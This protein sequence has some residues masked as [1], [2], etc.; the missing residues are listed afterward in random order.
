MVMLANIRRMHFRDRILVREIS[1]RTGLSRNTVRRWLRRG[2][3]EPVYPVRKGPCIIEAYRDLRE[4]LLRTDSPVPSAIGTLRRCSGA[5]L[6]RR[7][8]S[9]V[10]FLR[11]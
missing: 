8:S 1:E 11:R 4:V 9:G 5:G 6:S 3:V 2:A 10:E 7:L